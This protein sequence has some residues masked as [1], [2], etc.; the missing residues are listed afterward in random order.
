MPRRPFV[1]SG[2][3]AA[4]A[5]IVFA[6][7]PGAAQAVT[8]TLPEFYEN[9]HKLSTTPVQVSLWGEIALHSAAEGEIVCH[10]VMSA[11]V[12]NEKEQ[13]KGLIEGWGT[14]ACKAPELEKALEELYKTAIEQGKIK[15]PLTVFATSELPLEVE[16]RE[17][18]TCSEEA[19]TELSLCPYK[20]ERKIE[21]LPEVYGANEPPAIRIRRRP[22]SFPWKM[23]LIRAEREEEPGVPV[24]RIG[25]PG[26]QCY[27]KEIV[28]GKEV[29][30]NWTK[31]PAGCERIDIV[32]PQI[33]DELMFYGA[34][35]PRYVSGAGNGLN[36]SHM[37]FNREAGFIDSNRN[38]GPETYSVGQLHI[39]GSEAREL[40]W[41]K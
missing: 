24:L 26:E 35:A 39:G 17:F 16:H 11:S 8:L 3:L 28:E 14:N 20:N 7:T 2:A 10:D 41:T 9:A 5:A 31:V 29:P 32:S 40:I 36:A 19:K 27:P 18:E 1:A 34:Q 22:A 38:E 23:E 6:F 25:L 30:A 33:P 13:G 12:W 4:V 15:A 21:P 37:E